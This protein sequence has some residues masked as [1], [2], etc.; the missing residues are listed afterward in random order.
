MEIMVH[1]TA[2]SRGQDDLRYRALAR[3]YL[4][5][6][7]ATRQQLREQPAD[8]EIDD[9]DG[10]A[11]VQLQEELL[12]STQERESAASYRPDDEDDTSTGARTSFHSEVLDRLDL[13][14]SLE[15]PVLSFNSVLDNADSPVFRGLVTRD[16][17]V[18]EL[19]RNHQTQQST[20]SW[21]P[22][23]SVIA[24]S[25]PEND[26][27]LTAF[28]EPTRV[29]ELY[30]QRFDDAEERS[31]HSGLREQGEL[32]IGM[33]SFSDDRE[34]LSDSLEC[35]RI[36]SSP[37]PNKH[38]RI[39]GEMIPES[40]SYDAPFTQD[41]HL[42]LKRKW[43]ESSSGE[44]RTS[45]VPA[46]A[47]NSSSVSFEEEDNRQRKRQR[48]EISSPQNL[49]LAT[50]M[51]SNNVVTT[52]VSSP[53]STETPS[54]WSNVLEIR[55]APPTTSSG[56]LKAEMFITDTLHQLALKMPTTHLLCPVKQIR[57]LRQMERGYW[58]VNC[59]SWEEGLH[60]R[61]WTSL[62]NYIGK[63]LVGWGVWCVRDAEHSTIRVYCWGIIVGHIY[64]L[65]YI[66]SKRKI[67]GTGACWISGD[68]E[69]II[70]MP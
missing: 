3:S 26:R 67:K 16:E 18:S 59:H 29:L 57:D 44:I 68:G 27:A 64:L 7:P 35:S 65:L 1:V 32:V 2:A 24:D 15:S 19:V 6:E 56:D 13:S 4:V 43:P 58:L 14:R 31:P 21:R 17:E 36:L 63:N 10:Q 53:T 22:P 66:T 69:A 30:L 60:N 9:S 8:G 37:S 33:G 49:K 12:Q 47:T 51:P 42:N 55:P 25:Q 11:H 34:L 52:F 39:D 45:S 48:D 20:D 28:S 62:G 23:P 38:P 46:R 40:R 70:T 61:C 5:F 41:P 50:I 54:V